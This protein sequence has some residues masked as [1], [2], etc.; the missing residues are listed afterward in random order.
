M[1]ALSYFDYRSV[2]T[3]AGLSADQLV[4]LEKAVRAEF[5]HDDMM[6]E[7]HVLRACLAVRD[8]ETT[9]E[10]ILGPEPGKPASAA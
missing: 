2:A 8:G 3:E 6:Y 5:P 7:L 10:E 9:G 4:R 1:A